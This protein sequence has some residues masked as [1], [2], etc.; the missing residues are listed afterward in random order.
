MRFG[1]SDQ[2]RLDQS[3]RQQLTWSQKLGVLIWTL[4]VRLRSAWLFRR[5]RLW[6]KPG[7][8]PFV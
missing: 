8:R 4:P 5:L 1:R 3:W 2:I 6:I 7:V